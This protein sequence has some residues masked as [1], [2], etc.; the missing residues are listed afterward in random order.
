ML[1]R[2]GH[3]RG[4]VAG[5]AAHA[6]LQSLAQGAGMAIEDSVIFAHCVEKAGGDPSFQVQGHAAAVRDGDG[7]LAPERAR[8]RGIPLSVE[9]RTTRSFKGVGIEEGERTGGGRH[10]VEAAVLLGLGRG[11]L[12]GIDL[13]GEND[14]QRIANGMGAAAFDQRRREDRPERPAVTDQVSDAPE[15]GP[16]PSGCTGSGLYKADGNFLVGEAA[17]ANTLREL[18]KECRANYEALTKE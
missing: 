11:G 6:T 13:F 5:D 12:R 2:P 17:R 18:L 1:A 4:R 14:R 9:R 3:G 8:L 15:A 16:A 7:N 10:H